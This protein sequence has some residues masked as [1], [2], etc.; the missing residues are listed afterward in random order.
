LQLAA[1]HSRQASPSTNQFT[2]SF[3][4]MPYTNTNAKHHEKEQDS[5]VVIV[6]YVKEN[7]IMH[8]TE[9]VVSISRCLLLFAVQSCLM[10]SWWSEY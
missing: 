3:I 5:N 9:Q 1:T 6:K 4:T 10:P 8:E 7:P 2:V